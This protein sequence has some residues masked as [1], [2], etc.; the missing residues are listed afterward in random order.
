M[1]LSAKPKKAME[2]SLDFSAG[3]PLQVT[4]AAEAPE[5]P[6]LKK[7][8]Y[9][10][11]IPTKSFKKDVDA[12]IEA[13]YIETTKEKD[14]QTLRGYYFP[15]T[16]FT[17]ESDGVTYPIVFG[18][19]PSAGREVPCIYSAKGN[20]L[21]V[22]RA[23]FTVPQ[24]EGYILS[25]LKIF[26]N[27]P[28]KGSEKYV[29]SVYKNFNRKD[30]VAKTNPDNGQNEVLEAAIEGITAEDVLAVV[31]AGSD[32]IKKITFTYNAVGKAKKSKKK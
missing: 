27:L 8:V 14:G 12:A 22:T 16:A 2:V 3:N 31:G 11:A 10:L 9:G 29:F 32:I 28:K 23:N 15:A 21:R 18:T 13:G 24:I 6:S 17:F 30:I 25:G 5:K 20:Y 19:T 4:P 1:T 7:P 26:V